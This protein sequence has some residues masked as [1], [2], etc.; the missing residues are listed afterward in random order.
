MES[1]MVSETPTIEEIIS[2]LESANFATSYVCGDDTICEMF[3]KRITA[4]LVTNQ[5]SLGPDAPK[6]VWWIEYLEDSNK[7]VL[8][9]SLFD[10]NG[11]PITR[12]QFISQLTE[13]WGSEKA[14][15]HP[16]ALYTPEAVIEWLPA[17]EN[18]WNVTFAVSTPTSGC[19]VDGALS[20]IKKVV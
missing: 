20:T 13:V 16:A 3:E 2:Y 1:I 5:L 14:S 10:T 19:M 12:E 9:C 8:R 17:G 15:V 6:R 11:T 18:V 4:S 7:F